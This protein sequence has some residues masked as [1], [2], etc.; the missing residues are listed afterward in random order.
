M[1]RHSLRLGTRT[2]ELERP[3]GLFAV[4]M[5]A[6]AGLLESDAIA[7]CDEGLLRPASEPELPAATL[8][9]WRSAGWTLVRLSPGDA[10]PGLCEPLV[11][12]P[13]FR[14]P[15]GQWW[16][17]TDRMTVRFSRD[18]DDDRVEE[19]LRESRL[20]VLRALGFAPHL[21]EVRVAADRDILAVAEELSRDDE[22]EYA[23]P[24]FI[25]LFD[26]R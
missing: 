8:K 24:Q 20:E 11:M 15:E 9:A 21:F 23:E 3:E 6:D 2:I 13:V 5:P 4:R 19:L 18:L 7:R 17:G 25:E 10:D 26:S 16:I 1:P 14:T 12:A 22:V